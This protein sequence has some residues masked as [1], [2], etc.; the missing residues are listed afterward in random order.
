[1]LK[2]E[3]KKLLEKYLIF[4]S[5]YLVIRFIIPYFFDYELIKDKTSA[6]TLLAFATFF[7][8]IL[9]LITYIQNKNRS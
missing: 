4:L 6:I 8:F 3:T 9:F 2:K 1:M 5:I 7:Y